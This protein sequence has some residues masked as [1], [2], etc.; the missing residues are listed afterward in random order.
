MTSEI[1]QIFNC[2]S[3][4]KN[5]LLLHDKYYSCP[6]CL[7]RFPLVGYIPW[8]IESPNASLE[9]WKG[10]FKYL[11]QV[12]EKEA[13]LMKMDLQRKDISQST[14][15]RLRKLLQA[16]VEQ[17]KIMIE[18]LSPL[19]I[20]DNGSVALSEA[21]KT[22]LPFSQNLMSYYDNLHRDWT[23]GDRENE[24]SL[25]CIKKV[26]DGN[27]SN[28]GKFLVLGGGGC[29]LPYDIHR[30]FSPKCTVVVDINP[31]LLLSARKIIRGKTLK[32][33]EFPIA[34][35]DLSSFGVLR[36]CKAPEKIEKNFEFVFADVSNA[37]FN[38][39]TFDTI[40]TPW[41]IDIIAEDPREFFPKINYLLANN[42]RWI[43]FGS[44]VFN[45]R[46]P[47][48]NYSIE[49]VREIISSSGF[50]IE[51]EVFE[52]IPYMQSPDSCHGRLE[53]IFCFSA[54]KIKDVEINEFKKHD[55][56]PPWLSSTKN[57]VPKLSEFEVLKSMYSIYLD[58]LGEIDGNKS[59]EDISRI[60]APKYKL[61][62][63]EATS[64]ITRYLTRTFQDSV[65]KKL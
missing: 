48:S 14:S 18:L 31:L 46:G 3:C 59:I 13:D 25:A 52:S 29:R 55:V 61:S 64:S 6:S 10:Q 58:V 22:K 32:L 40:L 20:N 42:G 7:Q 28:L 11:L 62:F 19:E 9:E 16:K 50:E 2:P 36:K 39:S 43:N 49:E 38:R 35:K 8:L 65:E 30:S 1:D 44:L 60:F 41:L 53:K 21:L 63:D 12:L 34:P 26:I 4:H 51:N 47:A 23:W 27:N 57:P 56:L 33:Y 37:P 5:F 45:G 24:A 15:L 54:K 17:K